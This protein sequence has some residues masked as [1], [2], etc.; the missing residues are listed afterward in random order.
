MVPKSF[1]TIFLQDEVLIFHNISLQR[2]C[3]LRNWLDMELEIAEK[4]KVGSLIIAIAS[5]G[6]SLVQD[7]LVRKTLVP[8]SLI[9]N[10]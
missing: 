7:S 3:I 8:E 6:V 2:V 9:R 5:T 10:R 4:Q 1:T